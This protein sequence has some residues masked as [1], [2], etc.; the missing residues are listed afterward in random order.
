MNRGKDVAFM[1]Q[2]SEDSQPSLGEGVS[3]TSDPAARLWSVDVTFPGNRVM[4]T[5]ILAKN[6]S[7]ALKFSKNRYP[8]AINFQVHGKART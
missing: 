4:R 6:N 5:T 8:Q 2:W 1:L 3:R 7:Q